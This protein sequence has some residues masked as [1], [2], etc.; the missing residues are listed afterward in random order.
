MLKRVI[1]RNAVRCNKCGDIIESTYTHNFVTCQCGSISIDGGRVYL[2]RLGDPAD[3]TEL[4]EVEERD[5]PACEECLYY[6]ED[7]DIHYLGECRLLQCS[8]YGKDEGCEYFEKKEN[9]DGKD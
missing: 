5:I 8:Q 3:W 6:L 4:S 9:R 2:S 7:Q 1:K